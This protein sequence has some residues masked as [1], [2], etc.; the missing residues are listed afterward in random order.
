MIMM[1]M[2]VTIMMKTKMEYN[3]GDD[4]IT[5]TMV[6]QTTMILTITPQR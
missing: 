6:K 2:M 4:A 5:K 1:R 3:D